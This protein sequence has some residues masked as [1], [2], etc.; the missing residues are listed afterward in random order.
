VAGTG[1]AQELPSR[2]ERDTTRHRDKVNI[3]SLDG[4]A[5]ARSPPGTWQGESGADGAMFV[6]DDRGDSFGGVSYPGEPEAVVLAWAVA[7]GTV[8]AG[9]NE[10]RL[11]V[12]T[13]GG[14]KSS[15]T[16]SAGIH[17]LCTA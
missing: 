12:E 11:L 6:S 10:G 14:W 7:D 16:I 4:H 13:A 8:V 1:E 2:E 17:S 15:G 3:R 5:A 9:T